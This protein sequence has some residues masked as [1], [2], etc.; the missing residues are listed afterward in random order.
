[1]LADVVD[2]FFQKFMAHIVEAKASE[3]SERDPTVKLRTLE[4]AYLSYQNTSLVSLLKHMKYFLVDQNK[5]AKEEFQNTLKIYNEIKKESEETYKN[6]DEFKLQFDLNQQ[7]PGSF[8][9]FL[10]NPPPKQN[11]SATEVAGDLQQIIAE[12]M[13]RSSGAVVELNINGSVEPIRYPLDKYV[14][15]LSESPTKKEKKFIKYCLNV[16]EG[17]DLSS[18]K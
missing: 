3:N 11:S 2:D 8:G 10:E 12:R 17:F 16:K 7:F 14:D 9:E 15:I 1:M 4:K 13:Q 6:V 18:V 5:E